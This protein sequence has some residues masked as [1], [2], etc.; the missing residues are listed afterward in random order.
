MV[1]YSERA[2]KYGA[3]RTDYGGNVYHS[4]FEA[5][6]AE[7]LDLRL[8]AKDIKGWERQKRFSFNFVKKHGD[9]VL[10]DKSIAG[11][12]GFHITDYILDFIITH[13][14]GTKEF[15]EVKGVEMPAWKMK[16]KMLC[17]LYEDVPDVKITLV[18]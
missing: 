2:N 14:D 12:E 8:M 9:W 1:W 15:I 13:N 3:K 17:A 5:G 7:E 10:T 11:K 4:K 16:W 6:Y 18:K